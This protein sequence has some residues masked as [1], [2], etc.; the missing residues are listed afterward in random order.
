MYFHNL[1]LPINSGVTPFLVLKSYIAVICVCFLSFKL[2]K[3]VFNDKNEGRPL[4][5]MISSDEKSESIKK[6]FDHFKIKFPGIDFNNSILV[7]DDYQAYFNEYVSCFGQPKEHVLCRWHIRR[8]FKKRFKL[9]DGDRKYFLL[10]RLILAPTATDY[11]SKLDII[12]KEFSIN[13]FQYLE[14]NY[15]N[16]KEKWVLAFQKSKIGYNLHIESFHNILKTKYMKRKRNRR[17]DHLIGLLLNID[18][19]YTY[20]ADTESRKN[21]YSFAEKQIHK[22]HHVAT[23][24]S[25][26][27]MQISENEFIV[28]VI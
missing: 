2:L 11:A 1:S 12:R 28:I 15:L 4:S 25:D 9:K 10:N 26:S 7:S 20:K 17:V 27:V 16:R 14:K 5:H 21:F 13:D 23:K 22:Y 8:N 18:T 6:F 19:D 24:K 3:N